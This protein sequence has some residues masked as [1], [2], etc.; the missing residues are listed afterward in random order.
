MTKYVYQI[1]WICKF[2][3]VYKYKVNKMLKC[4]NG[5]R[6]LLSWLSGN[7]IEYEVV[8]NRL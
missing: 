8:N 7:M 4:Q 5:C 2:N 1:C 3:V 6:D